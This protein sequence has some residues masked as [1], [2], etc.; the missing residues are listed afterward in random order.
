MKKKPTFV[1][2]FS[3]FDITPIMSL[4]FKTKGHSILK[5]KLFKN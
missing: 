1:L 4:K 5:F 3:F 2:I